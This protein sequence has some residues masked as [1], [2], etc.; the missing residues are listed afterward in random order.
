M[1]QSDDKVKPIVEVV[2]DMPRRECSLC[3]RDDQPITQLALRVSHMTSQR[4]N[5]CQS[6]RKQFVLELL[7]IEVHLP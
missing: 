5:Y 1:F 6:C 7:K 3:G 4:V 2:D